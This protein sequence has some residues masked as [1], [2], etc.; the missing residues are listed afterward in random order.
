MLILL[1]MTN[2]CFNIRLFLSSWVGE[3]RVT[4][5]H[6]WLHYSQSLLSTV[7]IVMKISEDNPGARDGGKF[8]RS[9]IMGPCR[10]VMSWLNAPH[11][12]CAPPPPHHMLMSP[13]SHSG[14]FVPDTI[15]TPLI[16]WCELSSG[17]RD[18]TLICL[19]PSPLTRDLLRSNE[20]RVSWE[21]HQLNSPGFDLI[22]S[23]FCD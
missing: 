12:P 20:L 21:Y 18:N 2:W 5:S 14:S 4:P 8:S 19:W 1:S 15:V 6:P 10:G 17:P 22:F 16:V 11:L 7:C 9:L 23:R 3:Q 13:M